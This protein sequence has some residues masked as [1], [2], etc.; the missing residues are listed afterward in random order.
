MHAEQVARIRR[1]ERS[2]R[3]RRDR[4]FDDSKRELVALGTRL[5]LERVDVCRRRQLRL[6]R[7]R[8]RGDR[9]VRT[10]DLEPHRVTAV[11]APIP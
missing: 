6:E 2:R 1:Q 4:A 3:R 7:A 10:L 9:V 11:S 5:A 8:E